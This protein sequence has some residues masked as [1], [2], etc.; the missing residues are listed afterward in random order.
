MAPRRA[1]TPFRRRRERPP[2]EAETK[3]HTDRRKIFLNCGD[4]VFKV[5][6]AL[7][8]SKGFYI[9]FEPRVVEELK[10][11]AEGIESALVTGDFQAAGVFDRAAGVVNVQSE[12]FAGD[13][14][15]LKEARAGVEGK[16][17]GVGPVGTG[18]GL[19]FVEPEHIE[20][21][22]TVGDALFGV[23]EEKLGKRSA[24]V[25]KRDFNSLIA[26]QVITQRRIEF[27]KIKIPER[28]TDSGREI[29]VVGERLF[30]AVHPL[31]AS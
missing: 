25:G 23:E 10:A 7:D 3:L 18:K 13:F 16:P 28:K 22:G 14:E 27:T 6:E 8:A 15:E 19:W 29:R 5:D 24:C 21:I 20:D 11:I 31:R 17:E 9:W 4:E 1:A 26:I 12:P 2:S 30:E